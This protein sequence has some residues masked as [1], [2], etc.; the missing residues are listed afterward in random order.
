[1]VPTCCTYDTVHIIEQ[2]VCAGSTINPPPFC[3]TLPVTVN[4]FNQLD[5]ETAGCVWTLTSGNAA[6][7]TIGGSPL[8]SVTTFTGYGTYVFTYTCTIGAC[9]DSESVT[10]IIDP[11]PNAG[12]GSPL[13]ICN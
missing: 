5:N 7:V 11:L 4:L 12:V 9:T 3:G 2:Y 1:V 10:I 13:T 8:G 6:N